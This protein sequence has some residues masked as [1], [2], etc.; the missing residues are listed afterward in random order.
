MHVFYSH[1][2]CHLS[3]HVMSYHLLIYHLGINSI[4]QTN[5]ELLSKP[6]AHHVTFPSFQDVQ[7]IPKPISSAKTTLQQSSNTKKGEYM[8]NVSLSRDPISS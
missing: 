6:V 7:P 8:S 2:D 5:K 4:I 3:C 1:V